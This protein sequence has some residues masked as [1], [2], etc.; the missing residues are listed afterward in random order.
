MKKYFYYLCMGLIGMMFMNSCDDDDDDV[1]WS[2]VPQAVIGTFEAKFPEANGVEWEMEKGYYV[3]DFWYQQ[4]EHVAWFAQDGAWRMTE[5]DLGRVV[6]NLPEVVQTAF[7]NGQYAAW[8][9]DDIDK[10]ERP[11][12]TFYLIE[13]GTNGQQERDLYYAPDGRLLKDEV[14]REGNDVTP[15]F[16]YE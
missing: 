3:A 16:S 1:R 7:S 5:T 9:V 11:G 10:Y 6:S 13:V 8:R 2:N 12:D 14:D 15:E 4:S